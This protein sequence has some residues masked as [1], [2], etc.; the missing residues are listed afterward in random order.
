MT[1]M[2]IIRYNCHGG[3]ISTVLEE[4]EL[5]SIRSDMPGFFRKKVSTNTEVVRGQLL[6]EIVDS[7]RGDVISRLVAPTDGVIFYQQIQPM[8]F[9]NSVAFKM[10]KRIHE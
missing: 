5:L 8:V 7:F 1:R 9:Q 6:A 10:I 4:D 2:G 3:Y